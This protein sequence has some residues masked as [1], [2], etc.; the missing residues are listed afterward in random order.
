MYAPP[1]G[2]IVNPT[3]QWVITAIQFLAAAIATFWVIHRREGDLRVRLLVLLGGGMGVLF[4]ALGDRLG[5]IWH[6][7]V[8]QWTLLHMYGHFVPVWPPPG[9]FGAFTGFS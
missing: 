7:A 1:T 8:G 2:M 5:F 6:A 4:E 3:A 9:S